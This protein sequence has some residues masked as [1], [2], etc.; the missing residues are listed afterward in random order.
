MSKG[1]QERGPDRQEPVKENTDAYGFR[2]KAGNKV[3]GWGHKENIDTLPAGNIR[4]RFLL[5]L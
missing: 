1:G 3:R 2:G 5:G 4:G